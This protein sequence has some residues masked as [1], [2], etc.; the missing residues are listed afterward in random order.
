VSTEPFTINTGDIRVSIF[1]KYDGITGDATEDGHK[2]WIKV[3]SASFSAYREAQTNVGQGGSRQGKNVTLSEIT[4]TK[5]MDAASSQLFLQSVVGLGKTVNLHI[6]RTGDGQ[7]TNY[8]ETVLS[9]CCVTNYGIQ[10]DGV[11]HSEVLTLNFLKM[12]MKYIPVKSDGTPGT[13]MPMSFD[14]PTGAV[15]G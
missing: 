5:R 1:M 9:N 7:Q 11:A 8:M 14:I 10:S 12:E 2:D 4:I 3:N 15:G 13:P 6:T